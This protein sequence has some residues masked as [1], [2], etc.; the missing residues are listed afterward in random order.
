MGHSY[1]AN[2]LTEGTRLLWTRMF[3]R[4]FVYTDAEVR[5]LREKGFTSQDIISMNNGLD[6]SKIDAAIAAWSGPRL[7]D[8][9]RKQGLTGRTLVL[10]CARLDPKNKFE[11]I[12][13]ALPMVLSHVPQATWCVIGGGADE[14]RLRSRVRDAGL[15]DHVRFVGE[16]YTEEELAP[17]FLSSDLLVH[18]GAIGL[19]LLHAFGYGLPVVTHGDAANHGPEFAT[20]E[21]GRAGRTYREDDPPALAGAVIALLRDE[22]GRVSMKRY[23]QDIVRTHYNTD[24]M[25]ERF[26]AAAKRAVGPRHSAA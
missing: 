8:W 20:F 7:D 23:V 22:P 2:R 12:I 11:Q 16:L 13:A 17:W 6:Q 3:D 24:V 14:P 4:L 1:G 25:V 15:E 10:S 18:P 21:E 26:V 5:Y 19:S 9:R